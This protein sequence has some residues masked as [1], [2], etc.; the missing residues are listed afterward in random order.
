MR[1]R[2]LLNAFL[3]SV[4][5]NAVL[6]IWALLSSDF[7]QTEG[8]VLATSF[9]VSG[10]MLGVLVNGTALT[11]RALWPVPAVAATSAAAGFLLL[12]AIVW[13]EPD[14]D[15]WWKSLV[16]LLAT[17]AGGTLVALLA[18]LSLQ[19]VHEPLRLAHG[20]ATGLLVAT[21]I[22]AAWS[23]ADADWVARLIGVE[24]IVVAAL[25]LTVPAL[26]RFRPP[27]SPAPDE[28]GEIIVC[29]RCGAHLDR[30]GHEVATP[31]G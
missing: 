30:H 24:S 15:W 31:S 5:V 2:G 4:A 9:C 22:A 13:V 26:A 23:E 19:R 12:I 18:L 8:K 7:G 16:S 29:S 28:P 10:A 27:E 1:G 20:V 14:A 21:S 25:T 6:G 17:A 11:K 3:A